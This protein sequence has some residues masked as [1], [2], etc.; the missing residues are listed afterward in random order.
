LSDRYG[1]IPLN[2]TNMETVYEQLYGQNL[3]MSSIGRTLH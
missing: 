3:E 2:A 1:I